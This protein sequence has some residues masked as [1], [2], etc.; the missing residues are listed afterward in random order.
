MTEKYVLQD[1]I[2]VY[3]EVTGIVIENEYKLGSSN[4]YLWLDGVACQ[5]LLDFLAGNID[6]KRIQIDRDAEQ[7]NAPA[8]AGGEWTCTKCKTRNRDDK[9]IC[10]FCDTP[11]LGG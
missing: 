6:S 1:G 11:R 7:R 5:H 8:E 10:G 4:R 3:R 9:S 2:N